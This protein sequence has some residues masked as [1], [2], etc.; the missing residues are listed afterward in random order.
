MKGKKGKKHFDVK[1]NVYQPLYERLDTENMNTK[2][3]AFIILY[4]RFRENEFWTKNCEL[5]KA[6]FSN[7]ILF[8]VITDASFQKIARL[9]LNLLYMI[10]FTWSAGQ[11][12]SKVLNLGTMLETKKT[13][14]CFIGSLEKESKLGILSIS[15]IRST[16]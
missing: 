11:E 6:R 9:S 5:T 10:S 12:A 16:F 8:K 4:F 15:A 1:S 14:I 3:S 7:E 2:L 13:Q